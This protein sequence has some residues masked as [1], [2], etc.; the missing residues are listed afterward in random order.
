MNSK[1]KI[2]HIVSSPLPV[3][4]FFATNES[5]STPSRLLNPRVTSR[6]I[7]IW[8]D[9]EL[10]AG[11]ER[12]EKI[13]AHQK[14]SFSFACVL[15]LAWRVRRRGLRHTPPVSF[16]NLF[17]RFALGSGDRDVGWNVP[18]P[19]ERVKSELK[20]CDAI[21]CEWVCGYDAKE[22]RLSL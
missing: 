12:V 1:D 4:R 11:R 14:R 10:A 2:A 13:A 18:R 19:P 3:E 21:G 20:V 6:Q 9:Q 22:S 5:A 16:S 7:C 8:Q 15:C 17:P